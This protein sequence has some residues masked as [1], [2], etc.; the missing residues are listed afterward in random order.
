MFQVGLLLLR[1]TAESGSREKF[2]ARSD[3]VEGE[4]EE[5]ECETDAQKAENRM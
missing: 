5:Q 3:Q 4:C 1:W 2:P